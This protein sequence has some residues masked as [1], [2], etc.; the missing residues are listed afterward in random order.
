[1][2]VK[3]SG[4]GQYEIL[5]E[6]L[7]DAAGEAFDKTAKILGLDYPGGPAIAKLAE[8][9]NPQRFDFPR[10]MTNRP[11]LEFSF[12]GLK[13][14]AL[15]AWQNCEQTQQDKADIAAGFQL[16]VVETLLI[17]CER[18]LQQTGLK[19]LV[20]AGGVSANQALRQK[21]KQLAEAKHWQVYY[22][23]PEFCT[24]NGA[25]VALAGALR[26]QAGCH[27]P[28]LGIQVKSRWALN[29]LGV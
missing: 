14:A 23:R 11:G 18:A 20:M 25:M 12:S 19:Q 21:L 26:L 27:N 2:L 8:M 4:L 24:D 17:K 9:G 29:E 7:D 3:V 6:S 5:G 28:D 22:P 15:N 10:P 1:M 16:A 13:T